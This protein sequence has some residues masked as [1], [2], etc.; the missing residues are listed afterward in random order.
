MLK[1][2]IFFDI[3]CYDVFGFMYFYVV[4]IFFDVIQNID[5]ENNRKN[6]YYILWNCEIFCMC[7]VES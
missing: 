7:I 4:D 5:R 6:G 2:K 1:S 3:L